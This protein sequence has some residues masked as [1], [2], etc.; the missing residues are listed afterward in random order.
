VSDRMVK[1]AIHWKITWVLTL[2][3]MSIIFLLSSLSYPKQPFPS[4]PYIP[5]IEHIIEYAVL[6][7]LLSI[8]LKKGS[9]RLQKRM[10]L[11]AILLA[12]VY[13][14]SD[15]VHQFFV[16]GRTASF[17]DVLADSVGAVMGSA[18]RILLK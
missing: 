9:G 3:Y 8:A 18:V 12:A 11:L 17:Y 2:S 6:G 15:E 5:V 4:E 10:V 13:G 1:S 16:P 7:F 14:I